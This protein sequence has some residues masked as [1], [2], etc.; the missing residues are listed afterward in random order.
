MKNPQGVSGVKEEDPYNNALTQLAMAAEESQIDP[1]YYEMLKFP[2]RELATYIHIKMPDG[3]VRSFIGYRVQHNNARGPFKGGIRYHP[4]V[5]LNEVRALSMWMTWKTALIDIPFG[6][7]K[8]GINV[9]PSE[10]SQDE[11]ETLTR[12]YTDS[13]FNFIGPEVDIPAPDVGTNPQVMAWIMN[14]YSKLKG[15]NVPAVVTGKPVEIG[16][17]EGRLEAT[18]RGVAVIVREVARRILKKDIKDVT[19]AVQGFGNV[20]SFTVKFLSEM[21]AKIVGISDVSGGKL[22]KNGLPMSF[23]QLYAR[24]T[25]AKLFSRLDIGEDI[26]NEE[27]LELPVDVLIPA[28]IENQIHEG[29]ADRIN[30]RAIVEAAN[31][32][33][34]PMADK[35]LQNRGI[36][37][38]PDIL[39]N[40]GGV[41]V[42]YFEWVQNI[43]HEHWE[44][45]EVVQ[46]LEAKMVKAFNSMYEYAN[47]RNV[48][49]RL[50]ALS[51]AVKRVV[52][53]MKLTGWK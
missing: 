47:E 42:S 7:A 30:A 27:L 41:L 18:G 48:P 40:S 53:A 29:N 16:G 24:Y 20:G 50:A 44:Y 31:G 1:V 22:F 36:P 25:S 12:K 17:S 2:M 11:L 4:N 10:L 26:T 33:T 46:K 35:K 28:A 34:T 37:V 45:E 23:D 52:D 15:Y 19:V 13:V 21:G 51:I 3:T 32:P 38:I 39:V 14:E 6:G 5:N 43:E 8:G 49:Y 9:D